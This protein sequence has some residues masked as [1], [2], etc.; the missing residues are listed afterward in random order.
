MWPFP[1]QIYALV[2][3]LINAESDFD[4]LSVFC[5]CWF[6]GDLHSFKMACIYVLQMKELFVFL[7]KK[8]PTQISAIDFVLEN[9][10]SFHDLKE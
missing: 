7:W 8:K 3:S 4:W 1:D 5:G 10:G 6:E 2:Y 9:C